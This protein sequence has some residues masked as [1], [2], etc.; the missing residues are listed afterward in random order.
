ML[1]EK[2]ILSDIEIE[3]LA[4]T[5][6]MISPYV[7]HKVSVVDDRRI[8]SFGQSSYGYD[9]TVSDRI[10]IARDNPD[11][12]IMDI[13]KDQSKNFYEADIIQDETGTYVLMPPHSFALGSS[14]EYLKMPSDVTGLCQGKSTYARAGI[15]VPPTVME[16]SWEGNITLEFVNNTG[17]FNK[18][19]LN[20]GACQIIFFKG[21]ACKT[22]YNKIAGKYQGQTGITLGKV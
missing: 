17:L 1:I 3:Y 5:Q 7:D 9:V 16:A 12:L 11:G 8:P 18:L 10:L 19:Y 6:D 21:N 4:K 13:K 14:V 22:P 15:L 2:G 20:E